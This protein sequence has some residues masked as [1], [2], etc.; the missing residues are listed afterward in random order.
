[1]TMECRIEASDLQE[2]RPRFRDRL[3]S[4]EITRLVLR[5]E[6]DKRLDLASHCGIDHDGLIVAGTTMHNAVSDCDEREI[7]QV[8]RERSQY[9]F[10]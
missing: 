1:M 6:R 8:G 7:R 10:N 5:S 3:D 4:S 2:I 9:Q